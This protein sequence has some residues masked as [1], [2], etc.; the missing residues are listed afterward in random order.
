[1][2]ELS[3]NASAG[4]AFPGTED[5][6]ARLMLR[7]AAGDARAMRPLVEKWQKPLIS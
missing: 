7:V 4:T 2:S 6:D 3:K 1:M 5:E